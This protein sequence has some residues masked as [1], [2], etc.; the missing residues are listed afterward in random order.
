[1]FVDHKPGEHQHIWGGGRKRPMDHAVRFLYTKLQMPTSLA[2]LYG[3]LPI[4]TEGSKDKKREKSLCN[5]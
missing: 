4:N 3:K 5:S 2:I 1:M